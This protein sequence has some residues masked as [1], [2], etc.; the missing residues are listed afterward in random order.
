MAELQAAVDEAQAEADTL[1]P[2]AEDG[3]V[4]VKL[5]AM[6]P[7]AYAALKAQYPPTEAD[8][9]RVRKQLDDDKTKA[10]WNESD[11]APRLAA[12]CLID[13]A[14]SP[15]EAQEFQA[16]WGEPDWIGLIAACVNLH[17]QTVDTSSLVFSSGRTKS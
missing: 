9:Q 8:H 12:H 2:A 13:P 1:E 5:R 17:E 4:Q 10:R 7:L 3:V 11:F 16:A 15:E 14:V 6:P